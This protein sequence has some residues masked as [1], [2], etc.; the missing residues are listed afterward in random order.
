MLSAGLT[1]I[2]VIPFILSINLPAKAFVM[3]SMSYYW[4]MMGIAALYLL[5]VLITYVILAKKK[6]FAKPLSLWYKD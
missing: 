2:L 1:F 5:Y 6:S 3:G 4:L